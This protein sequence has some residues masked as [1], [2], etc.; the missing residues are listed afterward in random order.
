M[1]ERP[2]ISALG[3]IGT[4]VVQTHLGHAWIVGT[5]ALVLLAGLQSLRKHPRG[6]TGFLVATVAC[7]ALFAAA[8]SSTSHAGAS[9]ELLPFVVDWVHLATVSA[10][11]GAVFLAAGVVLRPLLPAGVGDRITCAAYIEALSTMATW[12]LAGVLATGAF[13]AWRRLGG[14]TGLLFSSTY[15][16]VLLVKLVLVAIAVALGAHNRFVVMPAALMELRAAEPSSTASGRTFYRVLCLESLV[17]IAV[18]C[19]AA[20][21]STSAPPSGA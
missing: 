17:L 10:W 16:Q 9:G 18:L 6:Q 5:A 12:S 7:S 20:V 8:K 13:S 4:V 14:S 19:A 11:A 21:L 2:L 1:A 15:G 3:W